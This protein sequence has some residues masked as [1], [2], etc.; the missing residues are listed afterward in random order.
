MTLLWKRILIGTGAVIAVLGLSLAGF[1]AW[2]VH[3][4]PS[5]KRLA[6]YEPPITTRVH[7]GDGALIGEFA[8]ENRVFVPYSDIPEH[9]V[10]AFLSAEDRNFFEHGGLD[11]MAF[12]RAQ[13]TNVGRAI[14]GRRLHGASTITQQV[15]GNMLL[16]RDYSVTRKVKEAVM[17]MRVEKTF[18]KEKILELYLNQIE[19]GDRSFGVAAAALNYFNKP[20]AELTLSEA[21][22]LAGLPKGPTKWNPKRNPDLAM[23][24]RN[25][26]LDQMAE[27]KKLYV[28]GPDGV[29]VDIPLDKAKAEPIRTVNRFSGAEFAAVGYFTEEIRRLVTQKPGDFLPA[30]LI[31]ELKSSSRK[32]GAGGR[33]RTQEEGI[34]EWFN[35]AGLSIRSTLDTRLQLIARRSL[36]AGLEDYDRRHGYRGPIGRV[37]LTGASWQ[38]SLRGIGVPVD[39]DQW[40]KAVVL[41]VAKNRIDIGLASGAKGQ[42]RA[43]D[44]EWAAKTWKRPE[45]PKKR[46]LDEGDAILVLALDKKGQY[47]L[48]QVPVANGALVALDPH[49]GRVFAMVGGYSYGQSSFNRATQARRQP[50]S[51]FKPF[52]YAA[53]LDKGF[54]PASLILDAPVIDCQPG[55][56]C[57]QPQ[58]YTKDFYGFATLR[59][60]LEQSRN[61]MTVRLAQEIGLEPVRDMARNLGVVEDMPLFLSAALGSIETTPLAVTSAYASF[62]N[63]GKRIEPGFIDRIQ[64]RRGRTIYRRDHRECSGCTES[65]AAGTQAPR[66]PDDRK[67]VLDPVT[68]FQIANMLEGAVT[69]GTG[70]IIAALNRPLAGKT[71]TTDDYRSA[72]FVGFSPDLVVGIYV[73]FDDNHTLGDRET[74]GRAAAPIFKDFMGTALANQPSRPF[75]T[76]SGVKFVSIDAR[77]GQL[78][79]PD[80]RDIISEAFRFGTEPTVF[81]AA[82][83]IWNYGVTGGDEDQPSAILAPGE[84]GAEKPPPANP[85]A[86]PADLGGVY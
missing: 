54:T 8:E 2:L 73:G 74:G 49:T 78:P 48:K 66:L 19:L 77:T 45:D 18:S 17:A 37:S 11:L 57:Y 69:R 81:D 53:A 42:L 67:Q 62:V 70:R 60:G 72:W 38:E 79:G 26:I 59:L 14:K 28:I 35:T 33:R 52:V 15:A 9:V 63:G 65:W 20:L 64:D 1:L 34:N 56:P 51:T 16:N 58:N 84:P 32:R 76:P 5:E 40:E 83:G 23:Q 31:A 7:A 43:P 46:G 80:S 27:N 22:L 36:R 71:G 30:D 75:R 44:A 86:R 4:L 85:P 3:D 47:A 50:G 13:I 39:L 55:A 21:A 6:A 10:N 68:A 29:R 25:L 82:S 61:A 12:A 24:R 41:S